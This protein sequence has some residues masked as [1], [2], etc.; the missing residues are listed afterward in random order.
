MFVNG[1]NVVPLSPNSRVKF[2]ESYTWGGMSDVEPIEILRVVLDN[3][4]LDE[5]VKPVASDF[6]VH[7]RLLHHIVCNIILPRTGKFEYVTFLD[8]FVMFCLITRHQMNLGHL[9]LNHKK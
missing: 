6:D 5:I 2:F 9:L 4:N 7:R 1:L 3:P 8:M